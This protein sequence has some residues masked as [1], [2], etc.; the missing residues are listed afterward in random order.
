MSLGKTFNT[1]ELHIKI[2]KSLNKTWQPKR[3][4][5]LSHKILQQC[6]GSSIWKVNGGQA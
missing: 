5:L 2:L 3:Q 4:P 6:H 1:D